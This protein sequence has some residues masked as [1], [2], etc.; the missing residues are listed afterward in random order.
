MPYDGELLAKYG[1]A[2]HFC[3]RGDHYIGKLC[4]LPG[5]YGVQMSQPHLNDME[6]IYKNTV[7]RGIKLLVFKRDVAE[8]DIARA[9]GFGHNLSV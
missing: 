6:I 4:S 8:K 3:G 7:D 5:L 9:G 2:E 1:G